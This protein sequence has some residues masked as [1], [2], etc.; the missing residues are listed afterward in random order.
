[1]VRRRKGSRI[2]SENRRCQMRREFRCRVNDFG[3]AVSFAN[4]NLTRHVRVKLAVIVHRPFTGPR[5]EPSTAAVVSA[6]SERRVFVMTKGVTKNGSRV[7]EPEQQIAVTRL[8]GAP[9][10][11][12]LTAQLVHSWIRS[13]RGRAMSACRIDDGERSSNSSAIL[14]KTERFWKPRRAKLI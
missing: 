9:A 3:F 12:I 1:M 10:R 5:A 13:P 14:Q 6:T 4:Q 7:G 11:E 8:R 2:R